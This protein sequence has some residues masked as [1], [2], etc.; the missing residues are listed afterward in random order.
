MSNSKSSGKYVS[1][2]GDKLESIA[3]AFSL[4]FKDKI[5]LDI[6]SSTGG[7][8]DYALQ[9]GARQVIAVEKGTKQLHPRL[10]VD[11]RIL[12]HEKTDVAD[13]R[14]VGVVPDIIL[15]DVSFVSIKAIVPSLLRLAGPETLIVAMIKPQF[16]ADSK[17]LNRG[18]VKNE[19]IRR[20]ILGNLEIELKQMLVVLAKADSSIVGDKGNL[21]RFFLLKTRTAPKKD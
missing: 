2:G 13:F 15:I 10:R 5:V 20:K 4:N 1:T 12:L 19:T 6:G 17:D 16:E 21:E 7:F 8:T 11:S 3:R 9:N 18:V 14:L